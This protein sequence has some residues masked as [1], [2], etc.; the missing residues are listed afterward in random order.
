MLKLPYA[1]LYF[2]F[3]FRTFS[4]FFLKLAHNTQHAY[5]Y[6]I[7]SARLKGITE[8]KQIRGPFKSISEVLEVDGFGEKA[9]KDICIRIVDNQI[10]ETKVSTVRQQKNRKNLVLPE[11]S[12]ALAQVT[13]GRKVISCQDGYILFQSLEGV[14]A[15]HLDPSGIGWVK[16]EKDHNMVT[17]WKYRNFSSLPSKMLPSDTFYLVIIYYSQSC[18]RLFPF[19]F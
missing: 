1:H 3:L 6:K 5:R 16:M 7:S 14:V 4:C 15:I 12:S 18:H 13:S 17:D 19:G 10:C 11:L 8:W 2:L 9:L